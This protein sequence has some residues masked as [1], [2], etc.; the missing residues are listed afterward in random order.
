LTSEVLELRCSRRHDGSKNSIHARIKLRPACCRGAQQA[1]HRIHTAAG[2][3]ENTRQK[4]AW[5]CVVPG[6][7]TGTS[8]KHSVMP[9]PALLL[10]H[11]ASCGHSWAVTWR[12]AANTATAHTQ[13]QAQLAHQLCPACTC[14]T[15]AAAAA[16]GARA[17]PCLRWAAGWCACLQLRDSR[18]RQAHPL[19]GHNSQRPE[20]RLV[21]LS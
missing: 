6:T 1:R 2:S 7:D 4:Q 11:Q 12:Q 16:A 8:T 21:L 3:R 19:R 10:R 5:R 17:H 18:H 9:Q 13:T 14:S 20:V 15:A